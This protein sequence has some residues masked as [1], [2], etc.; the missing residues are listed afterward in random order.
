VTIR[1]GK[2]G[3]PVLPGLL[4]FYTAAY[5]LVGL[6]V[7]AMFWSYFYIVMD[8][9]WERAGFTL[10]GLVTYGL[11]AGSMP[12]LAFIRP[13]SAT[14]ENG[15]PKFLMARWM[16]FDI[17]TGLRLNKGYLVA[18]APADVLTW[19]DIRP[20]LMMAAGLVA[21]VGWA[22]TWYGVYGSFAGV[23]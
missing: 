16:Y 9:P 20:P 8:V 10:A 4:R 6:G 13:T 3:L 23:L 21:V 1:H 2:D 14:H 5:F 22:L 15:Q 19:R 17:R 11:A 12:I 7:I 18:M